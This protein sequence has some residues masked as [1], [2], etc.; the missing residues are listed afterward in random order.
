MD[1]VGNGAILFGELWN[2]KRNETSNCS[3]NYA[4]PAVAHLRQPQNMATLDDPGPVLLGGRLGTFRC[5]LRKCSF[6]QRQAEAGSWN[7]RVA[8]SRSFCMK[9]VSSFHT[10]FFGKDLT[11]RGLPLR[12]R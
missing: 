6:I 9:A 3:S 8:D 2:D 1:E 11:G 5:L 7:E 4:I 12:G 10:A